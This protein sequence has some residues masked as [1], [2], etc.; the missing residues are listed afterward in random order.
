[1]GRTKHIKAKYYFIKDNVERGEVKIQYCPT[2]VMWDDVLNKQNQ[3]KGFRTDR[4]HLMN[5]PVEY[6][7][8]VEQRHTH[9][10][11]LP[12]NER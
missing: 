3:G 5:I 9:P 12:A 2:E 7:D 11:L 6:D 4:S 8:E 10:L 1:M